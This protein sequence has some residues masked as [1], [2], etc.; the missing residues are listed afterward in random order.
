MDSGPIVAWIDT[1]GWNRTDLQQKDGEPI[2]DI[3]KPTYVDLK[4]VS[5]LTYVAFL[6]SAISNMSNKTNI[7]LAHTLSDTY[8]DWSTGRKIHDLLDDK[9]CISVQHLG[10]SLFP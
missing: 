10:T 6:L 4:S 8:I 1:A 5:K 7:H 3:D 2:S 9:L